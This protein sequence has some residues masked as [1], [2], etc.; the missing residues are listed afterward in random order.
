[1]KNIT[2]LLPKIGTVLIIVSLSL[3][4]ITLYPLFTIYFFPPELL[5]VDHVGNFITI[6]KIH[7]EAP[8]ILNV[9]PWNEK[10][11]KDALHHG[12][13]Q[14][15][16]TKLPGKEGMMYLFAHSTGMPWEQT[17]YNTIFLRLSELTKSDSIIITVDGKRYKYRVTDKKE[18]PPTNVSYLVNSPKNELILQTCVP[19]GTSLNR[20]LIFAA[21]V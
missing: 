19:I 15:K 12:V 2:Q 11:Y 16:G 6:P 4:V 5:P 13:A 9:D 21:K 18:I 20:L 7:A 1:M 14:A 10:E 17:H 8:I 3:I